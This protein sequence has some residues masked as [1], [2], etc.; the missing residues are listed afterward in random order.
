MGQR[1]PPLG[2]ALFTIISAVA[3]L[4]RDLIKE[5]VM[6]SIRNARA[7]GRRIGRPHVVVDAQQITSQRAFGRSWP[8]IA[9]GNGRRGRHGARAAQAQIPMTSVTI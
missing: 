9:E 1:A 6:A 2:Q 8:S 3:Q 7:K 5:R 4:E